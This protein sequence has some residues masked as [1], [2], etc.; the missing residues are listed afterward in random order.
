MVTIEQIQA[1]ATPVAEA[2]GFTLALMGTRL[3]GDG[4]TAFLWQFVKY[5]KTYQMQDSVSLRNVDPP[6]LAAWAFVFQSDMAAMKEV[7]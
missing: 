6:Q 3:N 2:Q 1:T 7:V 5:S 4:T